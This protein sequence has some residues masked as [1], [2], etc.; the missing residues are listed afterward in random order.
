MRKKDRI[1]KKRYKRIMKALNRLNKT[2]PTY[3]AFYMYLRQELS[4]QT[5][6]PTIVCALPNWGV[7]GIRCDETNNSKEDQKKGVLNVD[8]SLNRSVDFIKTK[9]DYGKIPCRAEE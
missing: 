6:L 4:R 3:D 5:L 8:V 1:F 2:K 7:T 9:I